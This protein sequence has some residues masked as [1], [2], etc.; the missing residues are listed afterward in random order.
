MPRQQAVERRASDASVP[1][2][3]MEARMARVET[4]IEALLHDRAMAITPSGSIER[5]DAATDMAMSMPMLDPVNPALALLGQPSHTAPSQEDPISTID[6]FLSPDM[7]VLRVG[8]RTLAFPTPL[9]YQTYTTTF[10]QKL[11]SFHPC[12]DEHL[13]CMRSDHMLSKGDVHSDDV[14]FLGLNYIIFAWQDISTGVK[15]SNG[16]ATP[17]GWHW[18]QLADDVVGTRQLHGQGDHSLA[19]FLLFKVCTVGTRYYIPLLTC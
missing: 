10:F 5:D 13:F 2:L 4:M 17:P 7:T 3:S 15:P 9:V 8:N 12:I 6:P 16:N 19:Q 18:L 11:Q 14:C 1:G